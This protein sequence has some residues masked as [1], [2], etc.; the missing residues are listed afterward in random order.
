MLVVKKYI[1]Y[2]GVE[3]GDTGS[4]LDSHALCYWQLQGPI[5]ELSGYTSKQPITTKK[6][7]LSFHYILL[8]D[9][10]RRSKALFNVLQIFVYQVTINLKLQLPGVIVGNRGR[11]VFIAS[12]KSA[13]LHL[14]T[15]GK[16][17][18]NPI[19]KH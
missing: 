9:N 3:V 12:A 7:H 17:Y 13:M 15:P 6:S 2:A 4:D 8:S 19:N 11:D 10:D 18:R 16:Y 1:K 14:Q 5:L